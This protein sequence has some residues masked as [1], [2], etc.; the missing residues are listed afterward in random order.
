MSEDAPPPPAV[1]V[2]VDN[3]GAWHPDAFGTLI[4]AEQE[5]KDLDTDTL[6]HKVFR[7]TL[8]V[9]QLDLFG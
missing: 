3:N 9:G 7:Y 1:F 5:A 8:D 6:K 4:T 2:V